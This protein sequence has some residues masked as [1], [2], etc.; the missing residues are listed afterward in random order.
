[1]RNYIVKSSI[2]IFLILIVLSLTSCHKVRRIDEFVIP[3][4][5][6]ES[7]EYNITFWAKNDSNIT[8]KEIYEKAIE[9]FEKIYPNINVTLKSYTDYKA[10]YNDVIT[11]ISTNTT[12]NVCISYPDHVATYMTGSNVIVC[13]DQLIN[14]PKYGFGGTEIK[15]DSPRKDE[16]VQKFLDE[17]KLD[18]EHYL[19]PFMRSTEACYINKT[20]VES[21]GYEVPDILTWDFIF[22]VSEK[23]LKKKEENQV[24]IPFIYKSTDNM[25]IQMLAQK[26]AGY[27]DEL[28]NIE[29]FNDTTKE[30]LKEIAKHGKTKAFSTFGISSYPGNFFNANQ[31]IFAI[32]STAGATWIGGSAPHQD[33]PEESRIEFE[34]VVKP[35]PQFDTEN[36]LMISQGPSICVFNKKDPQEVLASWIFAQYLLTNDVQIAYS[37]TE[38][39]SPVTLKAQ[40]S[41]EYQDYLSRA[42]EIVDGD[43]K[44][45]YKVKI[46]ATKLLL[47]NTNN[48]FI[49]P[50]F[51]GS[52]SLRNA[53]GEM[54]ERVV[55]SARRGETIDD[56]Y[57]EKMFRE[58][59]LLYR[60][61]EIKPKT[62]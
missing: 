52:A 44:K 30:L 36:P 18:G 19:I 23:A 1:M 27:S 24:L 5:F 4:T 43:N 22:E 15:Y 41:S 20:Y 57:F 47:E 34:I 33:I 26:N 11:N 9:D 51:A 21:L 38:G 55:K 49:T 60:L 29:I 10:I 14:N 32:D 48:T 56:E 59:N 16:M 28:G 50:V 3:S 8:Q 53:A 40:N 2:L 7:R 62:Q 61:D 25:M 12:P 13:L 6:D 45:Y 42:G 31:C 17:C 35:I 54:I 58:V 39:Y 46:D 37:E